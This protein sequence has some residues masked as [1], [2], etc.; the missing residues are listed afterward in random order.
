MEKGRVSV[1]QEL[2]VEARFLQCLSV[3][4]PS[5]INR[6]DPGWFFKFQRHTMIFVIK[7]DIVAEG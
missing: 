5:S 6:E 4:Q 2:R 7:K 3:I 1:K